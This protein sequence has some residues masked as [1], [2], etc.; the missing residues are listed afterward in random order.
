MKLNIYHNENFTCVLLVNIDAT[1]SA[2]QSNRHIDSWQLEEVVKPNMTYWKNDVVST[3]NPHRFNRVRFHHTLEGT[4]H[5]KDYFC[6]DKI[7]LVV[8]LTLQHKF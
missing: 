7:I 3:L 4:R 1:D 8:D 5:T 6:I 2:V